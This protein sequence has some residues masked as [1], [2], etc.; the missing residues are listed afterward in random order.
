MAE[1]LRRVVEDR[2]ILRPADRRR[3]AASGAGATADRPIAG[4]LALVLLLLVGGTIAAEPWRRITSATWR[5]RS[6]RPATAPTGSAGL[7]R[8]PTTWRRGAAPRGRGGPRRGRPPGP[9][10][11]GAVADFLVN[12]LLWTARPGKGRGLA[13]TVGD[14]LARADAAV[15][16]RFASP[17]AD[18]G[19]DPPHPGRDL[20][21]AGALRQGRGPLPPRRRAAAER[22]R[23]RRPRHARLGAAPRRGAP[24]ARPGRR[25]AGRSASTCSTASAASSGRSTPRRSSRCRRSASCSTGAAPTRAVPISARLDEAM[26]RVFGPEHVRTINA[27][28]WYAADLLRG[29][30]VRQ[31][32]GPLPRGAGRPAPDRR[33]GRQIDVLGDGRDA[34]PA[35]GRGQGRGCMGAGRAVLAGRDPRRRPGGLRP[36][37]RDCITWCWPPSGRATGGGS[38]P[39]RRPRRRRSAATSGRTT[40]GADP[41]GMLAFARLKAGRGPRPGRWSPS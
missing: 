9:R 39:W 35:R 5:S 3:R 7:E 34:Q 28:Q 33:G 6:P 8:T 18:R 11:A 25:G 10:G 24:P 38:R 23:P 17:A 20:L 37:G 4:L 26:A 15:A 32:R 29:A 13:T 1:D 30:G 36:R 12:D 31:G 2:P 41:R 27:L 19:R 22:P 14:A 40:S 16:G 21:G